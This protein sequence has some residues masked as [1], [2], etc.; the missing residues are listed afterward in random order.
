MIKIY[1]SVSCG[2]S[3]RALQWFNKQGIPIETQRI[4]KI[5][6][7]D[8]IQILTLTD[9]GIRGIIKRP[10]GNFSVVDEKYSEIENMKFK[11]A[12]LYLARNSDLL[13]TPIIIDGKKVMIGYN[14]TS[15]REFIPRE[16]R[17]FREIF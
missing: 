14:G 16:Y 6:V 11:Q 3:N 10:R 9:H 13:R 15:I 17:K 7:V 4:K 8:I 2:S 5:S 12:V 1:Y